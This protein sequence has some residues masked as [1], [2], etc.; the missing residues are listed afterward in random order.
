MLRRI[1]SWSSTLPFAWRAVLAVQ[2]A[3]QFTCWT[4]RSSGS[5][6]AT[7]RTR[8]RCNAGWS[9]AVGKV[10]LYQEVGGYFRSNS[11]AAPWAT[12][13]SRSRDPRINVV[14]REISLDLA[15]GKYEIDFLEH[16]PRANNVFADTLSRFY[17]AGASRKKP[18]GSAD[19]ERDALPQ[20]DQ[21]RWESANVG[22]EQGEGAVQGDDEDG[23]RWYGVFAGVP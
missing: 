9:A 3:D 11:Q 15:E 21:R 16:V 18:E 20:R 12:F 17:Q 10:L 5:S 2:A 13:R 6:L 14:V 23:Q 22:D 19:A 8:G 1:S 7:P 4:S